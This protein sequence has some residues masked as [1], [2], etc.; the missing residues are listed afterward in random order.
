MSHTE[1]L[2]GKDSLANHI[3]KH[4]DVIARKCYQCGKCSAG[5]PVAEEMDFPPSMIMRL[6]Q[7][8]TQANDDKI[9]RSY[10]IWVCLT[11]E[12]CLCRCPMEID[13]P[14]AMDFLRQRSLKE[15][16]MNPKAKKIIAFHKSFLNSIK[17]TGRLF[18]LGLTL[19]YKRR[20]LSLMQDVP[21]APRM[22][23]RGKLHFIPEIIKGRPQVA[24]IFK[25]TSKKEN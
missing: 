20:S 14:S 4:I 3:E 8:E 6:L 2:M 5:C 18:E 9:L 1:T 10:S 7:T 23:A 13:I 16:K 15:K 22:I 25:K 19:D 24:K 12:M 11:C 17:Y 21:L